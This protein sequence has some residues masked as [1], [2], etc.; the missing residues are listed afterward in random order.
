MSEQRN[1]LNIYFYFEIYKL[2]MI[3]LFLTAVK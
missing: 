2:Y 1:E 3:E